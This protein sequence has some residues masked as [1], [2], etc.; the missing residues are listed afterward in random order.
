M[1]IW[2]DERHCNGR[3][4]LRKT[5]GTEYDLGVLY[6]YE[7]ETSPF[8]YNYA[9]IVFKARKQVNLTFKSLYKM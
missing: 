9:L 5:N 4:S 6:V 8:Y 1:A 3:G 7:N 2:E